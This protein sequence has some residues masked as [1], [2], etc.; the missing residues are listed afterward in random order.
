MVEDRNHKKRHDKVCGG[1]K[2][3]NINDVCLLLA[4]SDLNKKEREFEKQVIERYGHNIFK[5]NHVE[6]SK[7]PC[8]SY[9]STDNK[10]VMFENKLHASRHIKK[11]VLC[12]LLL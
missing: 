9:C 5:T 12:K 10:T 2:T 11:C 1:I 3:N 6:L 4:Y 7:Y 8:K